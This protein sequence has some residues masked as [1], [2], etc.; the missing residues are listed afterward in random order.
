MKKS[1]RIEIR[2]ISRY[3]GFTTDTYQGFA[4]SVKSLTEPDIGLTC[5][6]RDAVIDGSISTSNPSGMSSAT[7]PVRMYESPDLVTARSA[8]WG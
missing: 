5:P 3:R 7:E 6:F 1:S 2:D 4:C 8:G